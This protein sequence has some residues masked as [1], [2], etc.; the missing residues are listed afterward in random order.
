MVI[1]SCIILIIIMF[2]ENDYEV[3]VRFVTC[4]LL[5]YFSKV[6]PDWSARDIE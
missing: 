3:I 6:L 4:Y 5:S 2:L 1:E